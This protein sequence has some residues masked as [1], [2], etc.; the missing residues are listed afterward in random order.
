MLDGFTVGP[1]VVNADLRHRCCLNHNISLIMKNSLYDRRHF[2]EYLIYGSMGALLFII[3]LLVFFFFLDYN[4]IWITYIGPALF[5]FVIMWYVLQ[6]SRRRPEYKSTWMMIIAAHF[7]IG[8]GIVLSVLLTTLLCF[9]FIPGFLSGDSSNVL[10]GAPIGLNKQNWS[11]LTLIYMN[12]TIANFGAAG[13]IAV[14]G[15]YAFKKNQTTD[16]TAVLEPELDFKKKR[17]D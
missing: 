13:I 4:K 10:G 6:L 12:A 5:M 8:V 1:V 15:P 16:R 17:R 7:A 14:L 2:R 11:M 9:M 3:P